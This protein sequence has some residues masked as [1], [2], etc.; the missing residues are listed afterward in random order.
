MLL[1][2]RS[3]NTIAETEKVVKVFLVFQYR[4]LDYHALILKKK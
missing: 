4:L 2:N 3:V 1:K